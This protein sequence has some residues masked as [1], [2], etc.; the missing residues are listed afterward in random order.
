[1]RLLGLDFETTGLDFEKD[2]IIETGA[3]LWDTD[4]HRPL[5]TYGEFV[6]EES[7]PP[8]TPEIVGLT[9]ITQEMLDEFAISPEAHFNW[10]NEFASS[11]KVDY[12]VAHNGENFDKPMLWAEFKRLGLENTLLH[13][14][15]WIDTKT[16]LPFEV[17]PASRR[18]AHLALDA[19]FINPFA[20][21]ALFDVLTM[22]RVM[23]QYDV[24]K[25]IEYSKIPWITVSALVGYKD[26]Q[27]AKDA[28]FRWDADNKLWIKDIK[29]DQLQKTRE[30]CLKHFRIDLVS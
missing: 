3:V 30:E 8:L 27:L 26:R 5:V 25:I 10:L 13:N 9:G 29:E 19:G 18:L 6:Y 11:H 15:P 23:D 21:R 16:D 22:L 14:I 1:L 4:S 2:R 12:I 17:E 20:H 24:N 28:R 7:T